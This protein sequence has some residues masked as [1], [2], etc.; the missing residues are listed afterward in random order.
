MSEPTLYTVSILERQ[1]D[2][3]LAWR[4]LLTTRDHEEANALY[5]SLIADEG[6]KA[7]VVVIL[8]RKKR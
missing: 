4:G 3:R 7:R 2:G 6:V 8:P 5:A 1:E